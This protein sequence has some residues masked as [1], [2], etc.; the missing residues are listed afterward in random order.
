MIFNY[1]TRYE[2]VKDELGKLDQY[3]ENRKT[4]QQKV[5]DTVRDTNSENSSWITFLEFVKEIKAQPDF[6]SARDEILKLLENESPSAK[7]HI[8][9][10]KIKILNNQSDF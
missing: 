6:H 5:L 3:I 2:E 10:C 4:L 1:S 9:I 7:N 8:M